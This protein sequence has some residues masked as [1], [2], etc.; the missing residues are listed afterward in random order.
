MEWPQSFSFPKHRNGQKR[1]YPPPVRQ[2]NQARR[3]RE[4][5][6]ADEVEQMITAARRRRSACRR[7]R[8]LANHGR[9]PSWIPSVGADCFALGPDRPKAGRFT[10]CPAQAG[11]TIHSTAER[12]RAA[13][14]AGMEAR[15]GRRGAV[16][17]H[18]ASRRSDDTADSASRRG[19]SPQSGRHRV[20]GSPAYAA[21]RNWLFPSNPAT[22]GRLR[23]SRRRVRRLFHAR[24]T[25]TTFV[26][27]SRILADRS[28][29]N[30][31]QMHH[32]RTRDSDS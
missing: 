19:R 4:Y 1:D 24:I 12:P 25:S 13:G 16:C 20:S 11:F 3:T 26:N 5:L 22:T 31:Y 7:T 18:V 8:W 23:C 17:V 10:R 15:A 21:A 29:R 9:L 2:P 14:F 32:S 28:P 6:T 30:H 27:N